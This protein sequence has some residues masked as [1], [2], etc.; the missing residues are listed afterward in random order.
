MEKSEVDL[1]FPTPIY[2]TKLDLDQ[3]LQL[4]QNH[5][6]YFE[7]YDYDNALGTTDQNVLKNP[8]YIGLKNKQIFI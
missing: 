6:E 5:L 8:L 1:L 4:L 7:Y 3:N 2:K